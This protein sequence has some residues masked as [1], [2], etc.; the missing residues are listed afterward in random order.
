[1][2]RRSTSELLSF[3]LEI[4]RT[5]FKLKKVKADNIR[6]ED[7]NSD[8]YSEG[9]SDQ[10][11][12]PGTREPTLGDCWRSMMNKKYSRIRHQS[13]DANN[14]ELKPTLISMV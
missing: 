2:H 12:V 14:F 8:R 7:Q 4:E 13:N 11:E 5:L 9:H 6:I 3:D 1:M 10:N